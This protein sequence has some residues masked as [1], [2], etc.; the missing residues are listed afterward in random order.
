MYFLS[1]LEIK[2]EFKLIKIKMNKE[3]EWEQL[4]NNANRKFKPKIS[5]QF[6]LEWSKPAGKV[7]SISKFSYKLK[8]L[9]AVGIT[10]LI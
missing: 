10:W 6:H 2:I 3:I 7:N 1:H 9:P 4:P 5:T 8:G